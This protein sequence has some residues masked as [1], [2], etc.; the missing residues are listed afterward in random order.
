MPNSVIVMDN[1]SI[2]HSSRVRELVEGAG[3]KLVFLPPYSPDFNPIESAFSKVKAFLRREGR[4]LAAT[5]V[6]DKGIIAAA[7]A[8]I[9]KQDAAGYFKRSGYLF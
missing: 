4:K 9:T 8:S 5:G 1:A 6:P 7:L 2:H 3:R